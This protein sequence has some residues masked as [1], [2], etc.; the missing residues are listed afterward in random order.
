MTFPEFYLFGEL[1]MHT[2]HVQLRLDSEEI[3]GKNYNRGG[4]SIS[5]QLR[6]GIHK[7]WN[8]EREMKFAS[9]E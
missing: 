7:V 6:I 2:V 9:L 5:A 4:I 3:V 8:R 1:F